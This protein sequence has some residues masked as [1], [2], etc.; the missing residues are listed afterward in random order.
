MSSNEFRLVTEYGLTDYPCG[1][2]AGTRLRIKKEI[3]TRQGNAPTGVVYP[4]GETW[5]VL[6]GVV[7]EPG[8][9]WL[10]QADGESHTWDAE[11]ILD[12]FEKI[13]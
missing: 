3:V 4:V 10:R 7:D 6:N 8:I 1:L 9:I 11:D 5:T 2:S 13:D 12:T